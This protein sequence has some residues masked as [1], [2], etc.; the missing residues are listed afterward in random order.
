MNYDDFL[1][2][3]RI[4]ADLVGVDVLPALVHPMLFPF[5]R[6]VTLWALRKGRAAIFLECGLGKTF[7]QLEW[8]R[9]LGV[10]TLIVA[11]LSVA[12]QTVREGQKIGISVH[13]T[14]NGAD[15]RDGINITNYEMLEHFRSEDFGAVVLDESSILKALTGQTRRR[16]TA[17]FSATPYRLCCT[18]TPA[19]NDHV[20]L[21]NHAE[22]LGI[23]TE[24][25]MRAM[26]FIN[27]NKEHT[28]FVDDVAYRKKG[29]NKAGQEWRLKH[30]AE[31]PFFHWLASWAISLTTPSDLGYDDDGFLLPA[32]EI[33][34]TF[35]P[36][37]DV[38]PADGTLFF[39]KLKGIGDR[40]A[41]RK[42][43]V[44]A[45]MDA[46]VELLTA[47]DQWIVW[48]GLDAESAAV[49]A[50]IPGAVEVVG[51][52]TPEY[53]AE[54]F[55]AFQDG[56]VRVLVSKG[57]IAGFGLNFQNAHKMAFF[58]LNDSWELFY[59]CC[60]RMWRFG[61]TEPVDVHIVLSELEAEIYQNIM[62]KDA[63]ARRLRASLI[64]HV[65]RFEEDEL[66]MRE[67]LIPADSALVR[68]GDTW[69]AMRGDSCERLREIPDATV[70][71]SIYSPP[72]ADLFTY[73]DSP[74]D[75]GNSRG[76]DE[77]FRHYVFIVREVL[78]ITKPGRLTCVHT[79][80]IP[81]MLSRDGF[82]GVRD[83]PGAVIRCYE[84]EG[85]QFVGRAF[86]QKNPQA[87]AIR[88]KSKA[89]LFVQLRKDSA[90]SRPALIDQVL[91]FK[92][93][94][95]NAVP[96]TPVEHGE[97]D[98][99]TWIEWAH[100]I[101]TGIRE[102]DTLQVAEGRGADDEK[103]V[104]PLQ[105]GT[106]QRCITLYSNPG[107]IV[108]SPFMG[109]G[110][111]GYQAIKQGRRFVGCELKESY[112]DLAVRNLTRAETEANGRTLF[113]DTEVSA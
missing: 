46:L 10:R 76:W 93:P 39:T 63:M 70:D 113:A 110:S 80:D 107:E 27:A 89:L 16:V 24:A 41:V 67:D 83:F 30:S 68:R 96:V 29:S 87:Q 108:C 78:R 56:R 100:G 98:N 59:Q 66:Q 86:V 38:A 5:Q 92:A 57:R 36:V 69:T 9:I 43:T 84:D 51:S 35:V 45:R 52:D 1:R 15:L 111:E 18:A 55:E 105:L 50:A 44:T 19:P 12:R 91:I 75:L 95:E 32:L 7:I 14:R 60:R 34:P 104:C 20:E 103:H 17:M 2:S 31:Q 102:T 65:R 37:D 26:F 94:G 64:E 3:K 49:A 77:F 112:F 85:W 106:I 11:P 73:T 25:E 21:G 71:L 33:L 53:K 48:C 23:C 28:F 47:D 13:Y 74:R 88:V 72:F 62:R 6:D 97:I 82:I 81:A 22:F 54:Q 40:S 8:A 61:Q 58:G 101:W 4:R 79:S 99:E 42:S 90:D 109:I